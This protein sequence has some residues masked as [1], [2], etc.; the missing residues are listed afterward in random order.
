M[1]QLAEIPDCAP[2]LFTVAGRRMFHLT[3]ADAP[4]IQ[5]LFARCADYF[6]LVEGRPAGPDA[7]L[8][9][10]RDGPAERVPDD[11]VNLGIA[12]RD[13]GLAGLFGLLRH[14]RRPDQWYLGLMLLD[15]A[16]RGYGFGST[17]YWSVQH[18]LEH[19]GAE[20]I[21]LAVVADNHRADR[22]WRS[23]G[24]GRPRSYPAR[25]IGLKRHILIESEKDLAG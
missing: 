17:V 10:L 9:Q 20:S 15:P 5:R 22:F 8:A 14:H 24:F 12:D 4:Q 7:A 23:L 16:W 13:G 19:Q 6:T 3:E 25:R 18:W 21:V 2:P 1:I 11:L